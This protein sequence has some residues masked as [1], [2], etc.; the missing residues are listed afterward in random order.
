MLLIMSKNLFYN[1]EYLIF[2][3]FLISQL[4]GLGFS[5]SSYISFNPYIAFATYVLLSFIL[6]YFLLNHGS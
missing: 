4:M 1:K 3:I 2:L 5:N 6:F